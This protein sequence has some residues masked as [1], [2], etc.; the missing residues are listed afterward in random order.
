VRAGARGGASA[1]HG[2]AGPDGQHQLLLRAGGAGQLHLQALPA[3]PGRVAQGAGES[4]FFFFFFFFFFLL[5]SASSSSSWVGGWVF[6]GGWVGRSGGGGCRR[7]QPW[8]WRRWHRVV[9]WLV[10]GG[11]GVLVVGGG[12]WW[13]VVLACWWLVALA[14]ACC[15]L[16]LL[17]ALKLTNSVRRSRAFMSCAQIDAR[18]DLFRRLSRCSVLLQETSPKSIVETF[19]DVLASSEDNLSILPEIGHQISELLA[20]AERKT[21]GFVGTM[22]DALTQCV[23]VVIVV[24]VVVVSRGLPASLSSPPPPPPLSSS[25]VS[26]VA[27]R[28]A[29]VAT[30]LPCVCELLSFE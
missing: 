17:L 10:V 26:V 11:A 5:S 30:V 2:R 1:A 8:W 24:V 13:L 23:V 7:P 20:A 14:L 21:E 9:G 27:E 4:F 28:A 6:V 25:S 16:L 18:L 19:K 12:W 3:A 15:L 29:G 22:C